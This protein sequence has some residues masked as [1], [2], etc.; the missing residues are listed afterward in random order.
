MDE[1]RKKKLQEMVAGGKMSEDMFNEIMSRWEENGSEKEERHDEKAQEESKTERS[2]KI[3]ISGSGMIQSVY[4]E[5]TSVSGSLTVDGSIDSI[6]FHVSGSCRVEKDVISSDTIHSSGSMHIGGNVRGNKIESS[7]SLQIA[8]NMEAC[9]LESSGSISA[10]SVICDEFESSGSAKISKLLRAKN[11]ENSGKTKAESIE[12]TMLKS[13]GLVEVRTVTG[14]EIY[15]SGRINAD[16]ISSRR[17]EMKIYNSTSHVV[18]LQSDIVEIRLQK[19]RFLSG[20]AKI[21]EIICNRAFLE[22]T[23]SKY[24]KGDDIIIEAGCN[25][26]Y[27]EAKSLKISDE[28]KVKEKKIIP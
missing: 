25:I 15:I 26:D 14:D 6:F 16:S 18:K 21:D 13:S 5:E 9:E 22:S 23:N 7:G 2:K 8:G 17:F 12:C 24:V 3:R 20:E 10:E 19:K 1:D 11:I 4:A 27:V 28:A